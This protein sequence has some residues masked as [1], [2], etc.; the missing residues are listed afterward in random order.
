MEENSDVPISCAKVY[1]RLTIINHDDFP[2]SIAI[3]PLSMA[4]FPLSIPILPLSMAIFLLSMAIFPLSSTIFPLSIPIFH[5]QWLFSH[6]EDKTHGPFTSVPAL[7]HVA[8]PAA[9]PPRTRNGGLSTKKPWIS[10]E[11]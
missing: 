5:Y 6:P 8:K 11:I 7:W 1:Q 3:F 2:L 9:P 10:S 4:I